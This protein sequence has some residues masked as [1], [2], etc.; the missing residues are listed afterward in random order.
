M[1]GK[2]AAVMPTSGPIIKQE[3]KP[4]KQPSTDLGIS[5]EELNGLLDITGKLSNY[6][7]LNRDLA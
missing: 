6:V 5:L 2:H 3:P 1:E 4:E 7:D